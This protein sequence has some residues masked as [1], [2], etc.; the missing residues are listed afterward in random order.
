MVHAIDSHATGKAETE[1]YRMISIAET[2]VHR[3]KERTDHSRQK[4]E[5]KGRRQET[6]GVKESHQK[7]QCVCS[8]VILFHYDT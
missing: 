8:D 1:P 5:R 6:I 7:H 2:E 3:G 4:T